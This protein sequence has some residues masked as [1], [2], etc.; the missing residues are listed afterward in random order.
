MYA[1][2]VSLIL[3]LFAPQA[4]APA[5]YESL[6]QRA[7]ASYA[8]KSFAQAHELYEEASHLKLLDDDRRWVDF[9]LAD[10][11]WRS[12]KTTD[13]SALQKFIE[14]SGDKHDRAWAEANESMGDFTVSRSYYAN[15][16]N[17][18]Y[19]Q[20]LDWWAGS[21][22]LPLARRRYLALVFKMISAPPYEGA[23]ENYQGVPREV[24][25][26][27]LTIA[28]SKQDIA[29]LRFALA[30]QLLAEQRPESIERAMELL[31]A[32][33]RDQKTTEWYDDAL[34]AE[35]NQLASG[36]DV[37]MVDG[38][39][40]MKAD[41]ERALTLYRRIL[42]EFPK[43]TTR[44]YDQAQNAVNEITT[45]QIAAGTTGNF[46]PDSEQELMLSWRNAGDIEISI[47]RVDLTSD[48]RQ[49][50]FR[51][52]LASIV[53]S[54][55]P[56]RKWTIKPQDNGPH[57]PGSD[58][59]RITPRLD[60]GAYVVTARTAGKTAKTILLVSDINI[61]SHTLGM[62][63]EIYVS[64]VMRG[65][66]IAGARV[67]VSDQAHDTVVTTDANGIAHV[68]L[69]PGNDYRQLLIT[70]SAGNRQA[71]MSTYNYAYW[72]GNDSGAQWRVYAFTD[73]P[74]YRPDETV[75]WKA[76]VRVRNNDG[77]WVT[78]AKQSLDYVITDPRGQK[79]ATGTATLNEYGSYWADLKLTPQMPLG[80]YTIGFQGKN[81]EARG[82]AQ[83]FALEEY[84][85]P[86]YV[87]GV[88]IP[89][90][91]RLGDTVEAVVDA[92]Y[93]FGG[94]VANATVEVSVD[95]SS[96]SPWWGVIDWYTPRDS[97]GYYPGA[98]QNVFKQTLRTDENGRA[99]VRFDTQVDAGD[100]A[101]SIS[102]C[103]T[104]ASRRQVCGSG[105]VNV[106]RQRYSVH[107][108]NQHSIGTPGQK[109]SVDFKAADSKEQP[110]KT[111]GKVHV[112]RRRWEPCK[113]GFAYCGQY[114]EEDVLTSNVTTN[115]EG[116]GTFTFTPE[117]EGYYQL[118]WSSEDRTPGKP[119]RARDIVKTQTSLW[120]TKN[121]TSEIGYHA[122]GLELIVDRETLHSG[123]HVPLI[124]ATEN[125]D[126]YVLLTISGASI[127]DTRLV[128]L[129]GTMKVV[130]F[131]IDQRHVPDFSVTASSVFSRALYTQSKIL[132]VPPFDKALTVE[133]K[134]DHDDYKPHGKGTVTITT[135]DSEGRP[136]A[137][138]VALSVS[139][140][141]V[142]AIAQDMAGDP[143]PFFYGESR[144]RPVT[145][146]AG[147]QQQRFA[148]L[149]EGK[150][151]TLVD[152]ETAR[153]QKEYDALKKDEVAG[154]MYLDGR[155]GVAQSVSEAVTT[156]AGA[157]AFDAAFLGKPQPVPPPPAPVMK[158]R[159]AKDEEKQQP[160]IDVVVR[161]DFRS[162]AF[163]K[164]DLVTN[165]NGTATAT[166]DYPEALTE[167]RATAR[168]ATADSR[169]G[170]ASSQT[171]TKLP[172]IVRLE[173]PRFFVAG[174]RAVISAVV[175]NNT[176]KPMAVAPSLEATGV[177]VT[178]EGA[179]SL[180]VP[181]HGE[182]RAEWTIAADHEGT[183]KLRVSGRSATEGDAME[184]SFTVYEHG[185]DKLV[186]R[187]GKIR[188]SEAII[189]LALPNARRD[190]SL[191]VN[192]SPSLASAMLD[193]LPY[194][195]EYPYGCTE[196]TMS[197]FLPAS[198][199]ARAAAKQNLKQPVWLGKLNDVTDQ[200]VRRLY[201]F[202]HSDGG[203]GWWKD[204]SSQTFMTAYVIWGFSV[205]KEGEV[206]V[207]ENRIDRAVQWLD[208]Q[209]VMS[210]NDPNGEAW[211]LHA[212]AAWRRVEHQK[213]N[214]LET[215]AFD[216]AWE[217]REQLSA[218]SRALLALAAHDFGDTKRAEVLVRNLENGVKMDRSPDRSVLV[219]NEG[220]PSAPE[221]MATAH[222]GADRFWWHWYEGPIESTAFT[223]QALVEIDP[224]NKLVEPVMNWLV[225]NRRGARWNNTRDT[226]ISLLALT[227]YLRASGELSGD[228][229]YELSVNGKVIGKKSEAGHF[230]IDRELV[231]DANEI[232]IRRTSG[233]APLY[234]SVEGRFVSLE[235]PVTAAGH[236]LFVKREYLRLVPKPT[237]LKGV[238]YDKVPMADGATIA[239][240]DRV[241]V[242][243]TIET[244]ND[245]DYLLFEDL[246]PAGFE[247]TSLT[248]GG[249][250]AS[251]ENSS[252]WVYQELRDRKIAM[253][254]SHLDQGIWTI[255]YQLRAETPGSFH[256]L[257]LLGEAMYVPEVRANGEETHVVVK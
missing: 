82:A 137:A 178:S 69:H 244:K 84:K 245:Y 226:A 201:D 41:F 247:A 12:D 248:S 73:R 99:I 142:T 109:I 204:D 191:T 197:R 160:Q 23:Q 161:S 6:K 96:Y 75:H 126:R 90:Q 196:Q 43:G 105:S 182:A 10:T 31:D 186:A 184:K 162:T 124:I 25:T 239:S 224:D 135:K 53:G 9:R 251:K 79:V 221:T 130:E 36:G 150:D 106:M 66:P 212:L 253:F 45:P 88:S 30:S 26:N 44:Y 92:H 195:I 144:V 147:V 183:A 217:H 70:A 131:P 229:A 58:R 246:K 206:A 193:A 216:R 51:G 100:S 14:N 46:L 59:V 13:A 5:S 227:D 211:M 113:N 192:V 77:P 104:D 24:L 213:I 173:G 141:S 76:L 107:A 199:V 52:D 177:T 110:V 243:V 42:A 198:I 78:P 3:L 153:R 120:I 18:N 49:K 236:E 72:I 151:G 210:E 169:F 1:W 202:Q 19:M 231:R 139:D 87:V 118:E 157:P 188:G 230:T 172:L 158:A 254:A 136:V 214:D 114:K 117:R 168:V 185:I 55:S 148:K 93:Y 228:A 89:N 129:D 203:W 86:E 238:V 111:T 222:W 146:A 155:M 20:A 165:A 71:W 27:A 234:F 241:E 154:N 115:D 200:S 232:T 38:E 164:P 167:W 29:R 98:G 255:R 56:I 215:K 80:R 32:L 68:E 233:K 138:E 156:T 94:P 65:A 15:A 152:E 62:S 97:R 116:V 174:D 242:V 163:W 170:M 219:G 83:L 176:D 22:D 125:S 103:A 61:V 11:S 180:D 143:R 207:D 60:L 54:G 16:N 194:L 149:V 133:V 95:R 132:K 181:P 205:A 134:S 145:V 256:A 140:E 235:E 67:R 63:D 123:D 159:A 121:T 101:Y 37:V 74:A 64:D 4:A 33:I 190:T 7:E 249:I 39:P 225:K 35:A 179:K 108:Q 57:F 91:Y 122:G 175:N 47:E 119:L 220:T 208:M 34:F 218:Y 252:E 127:L 40:R 250:Y 48:L 50:D 187:S 189:Q 257:P 223:L 112:T 81:G 166:F 171:H 17:G 2:I 85:L 102:A 28:E 240:G 128:H 209:L 237:L 8:E 21:D